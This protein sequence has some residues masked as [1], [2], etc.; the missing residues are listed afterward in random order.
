MKKANVKEVPV[1]ED[2]ASVI[3]MKKMN[4]VM[5]KMKKENQVGSDLDRKQ[6]IVN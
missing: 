1:V 2:V 4:L 3:K 6:I 5:K